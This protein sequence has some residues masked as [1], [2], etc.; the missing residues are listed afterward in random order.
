MSGPINIVSCQWK[1]HESKGLINKYSI[2]LNNILGAG[3][4]LSVLMGSVEFILE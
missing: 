1:F 2:Y 4:W 3:G